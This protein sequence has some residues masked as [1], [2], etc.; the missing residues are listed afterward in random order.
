MKISSNQRQHTQ[1]QTLLNMRTFHPS[2]AGCV[3]MRLE[4]FRCIQM[5]SDALRCARMRSHAIRSCLNCLRFANSADP[6]NVRGWNLILT[7][8]PNLVVGKFRRCWGLKR[9]GRAKGG[10][11]TAKLSSPGH[12]QTGPVVQEQALPREESV[13]D[14]VCERMTNVSNDL[15]HKCLTVC[16]I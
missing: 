8:T 7:P 3:W 15:F 4:A 12:T 1:Q 16:T 9:V 14:K 2:P 11:R 5:P 10:R 13:R 6:E